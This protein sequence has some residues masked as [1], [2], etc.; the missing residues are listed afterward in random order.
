M[1][2]LPVGTAEERFFDE[3]PRL[4]KPSTWEPF[5]VTGRPAR[6]GHKKK[7]GHFAQ[8]DISG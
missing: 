2:T 3:S 4:D 5:L 8:N 6:A 7:S 1:M